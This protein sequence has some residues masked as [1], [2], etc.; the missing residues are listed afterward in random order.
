M[1]SDEPKL[2][3]TGRLTSSSVKEDKERESASVSTV[4]ETVVKEGQLETYSTGLEEVVFKSTCWDKLKTGSMSGLW[5]AHLTDPK[6]KVV[7]AKIS[8]CYIEEMAFKVGK[9]GQKI[10]TLT[11]GHE[12]TGHQDAIEAAVSTMVEFQL[13][14]D[15]EILKGVGD[16]PVEL[17]EKDRK[18]VPPMGGSV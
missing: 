5:T 1:K 11:L 2:I 17:D 10:L 4:L 6:N 14:P 15:K 12:I 16:E 8:A 9:E 13:I 3:L 7:F 18:P